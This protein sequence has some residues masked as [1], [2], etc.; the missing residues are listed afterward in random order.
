MNKIIAG[1]GKN[2]NI[3]LIGYGVR[4]QN[5]PCAADPLD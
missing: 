2:I 4:G 5:L 1:D 3:A